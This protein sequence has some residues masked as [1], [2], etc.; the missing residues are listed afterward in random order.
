[1]KMNEKKLDS[2]FS[3]SFNYSIAKELGINEAI[4][5]NH[6]EYWLRI[7]SKKSHNENNVIDGKIWMFESVSKMCEYLDFLS[8]KQVYTAIKNLV[9]AGYLIEGSFNKNKFD[10]S[11]WY[12][13]P[14]DVFE[15][16]EIDAILPTGQI[17]VDKRET[18]IYN[19]NTQE[20]KPSLKE[21][22]IYKKEKTEKPEKI[23]EGFRP[24]MQSYGDHVKLQP[25]KYEKFCLELGKEK[26]DSV[27]EDINNYIESSGRKPYPS[28]AGAIRTFL[29]QQKQKEER[30]K[31]KENPVI[32]ECRAIVEKYKS[33]YPTD[34]SVDLYPTWVRDTRTDKEL[35]FKS[36]KNKE[37][38][39][40][41][42]YD[43]FIRRKER[44]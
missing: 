42:F 5:F 27:I 41:S 8:E 14:I 34:Y 37:S 22:K 11:K 18:C 28:Y 31:P 21:E 2:F 6:I 29:K 15:V 36:F 39:Y 30:F 1:M 7:N 3:L 38:F 4:I 40:K 17:E 19:K 16:K 12:T 9:N 32:A 25:E 24:F 35:M 10:R 13:I 44:F 43:I 26:I 23:P 20:E 33:E